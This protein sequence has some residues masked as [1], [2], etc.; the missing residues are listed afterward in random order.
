MPGGH[1]CCSRTAAS[2][3][4]GPETGRKGQGKIS[5]KRT[6]AKLLHKSFPGCVSW[7]QDSQRIC[8]TSIHPPHFPNHSRMGKLASSIPTFRSPA[9]ILW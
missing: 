7:C 9:V 2:P 6:Q 1:K 4:G 5:L 3:R 8:V